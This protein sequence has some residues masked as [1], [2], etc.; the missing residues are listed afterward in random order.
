MPHRI[1]RE[2]VNELR[3]AES[4][5]DFRR[6]NVDIHFRIRQLDEKQH[7]RKNAGRNNVAIRVA[8]RVKDQ[9]V[10]HQPPVDEHVDAVAIRTVN[11][12]PRHKS[13][14]ANFRRFLAR[15]HLLLGDGR[16]HRAFRS[17]NFHQ[18]AE[19]LPPEHLINALR[20]LL[21]WRRVQNFLRR[22][23]EDEMR[24]GMR[25]GVMRDERCDV[26]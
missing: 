18:F 3:V 21:H 4:H 25:E 9:P 6:M 8:N 15:L 14:N 24:F 23:L 26:A 2:I 7:D 5:F 22:R 12:R 19:R 17:R 13:R 16:A 11:F 10:A 1:A 20:Q